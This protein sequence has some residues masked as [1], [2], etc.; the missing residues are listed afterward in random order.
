MLWDVTV[1]GDGKVKASCVNQTFVPGATERRSEGP[2]VPLEVIVINQ[3]HAS[4]ETESAFYDVVLLEV[5]H[6]N[7]NPAFQRVTQANPPA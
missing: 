2:S 4:K 1:R 3:L 5:T 7:K 6:G